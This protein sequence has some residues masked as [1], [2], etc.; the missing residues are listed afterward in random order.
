MLAENYAR[1]L[2]ELAEPA[3]ALDEAADDLSDLAALLAEHPS[4]AALFENRMIDPS[5]RAESIDRIFT[6]RVHDLTLRFLQVLNAKGRLDRLEPIRF[7]FDQ[8]V[9]AHRGQVD[10]QVH[11]AQPLDPAQLDAV[12]GR[13]SQV[14]GRAAIVHPRVDKSLIGGLKVRVGDKVIDATVA[15]QLRR[16]SRRMD[17]RG[18]E[19]VRGR[20]EEI[21]GE[22]TE[23]SRG[24]EFEGARG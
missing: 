11:T 17:R 1:A 12:T 19:A 14:L 3:G 5:R 13:I 2:F 16:L 23:G 10:V 9:K 24:R 15:A 6:G 22:G 21:V 18:H 4:L 8:R 7:A 20:F